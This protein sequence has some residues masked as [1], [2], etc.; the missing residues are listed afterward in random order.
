MTYLIYKRHAVNRES[1]ET[2]LFDEKSKEM[3]FYQFTFK[4]GKTCNNSVVKC[5]EAQNRAL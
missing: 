1:M 3:N 2:D 5:F 4:P